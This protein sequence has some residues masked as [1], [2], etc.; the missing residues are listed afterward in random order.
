MNLP[1]KN[2]EKILVKVQGASIIANTML[3]LQKDN[4]IGP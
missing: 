2:F 4:K 1:Y 3:I